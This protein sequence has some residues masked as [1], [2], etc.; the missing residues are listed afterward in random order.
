MKRS[1]RPILFRLV[2]VGVPVLAGLILALG[3][4]VARQRL[5]VV[6]TGRITGLPRVEWQSGPIYLEE[7]G[8]DTTGHRYLYDERLGWRNIPNWRATTF[9]RP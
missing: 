6:R 3:I 8:H 9:G 2:A 4:L 5:T 1:L 7:P